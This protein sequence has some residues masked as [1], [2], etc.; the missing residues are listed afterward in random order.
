MIPTTQ[1]A[2]VGGSRVEASPG[3][4]SLRP[5]LKTK[6]KQKNWGHGLSGRI[7][8]EAQSSIPITAPPQEKSLN[9]DLLTI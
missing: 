4:V 1:E 3:K 5:Y 8:N 7:E 6:Y 9:T 2:E